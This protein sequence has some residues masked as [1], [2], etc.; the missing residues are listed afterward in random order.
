[1]KSKSHHRASAPIFNS[2]AV[3]FV[4][5]IYVLAAL[6][7]LLQGMPA[8]MLPT[9][10][11]T[12]AAIAGMPREEIVEQAGPLPAPDAS[13]DV[14]PVEEELLVSGTIIPSRQPSAVATQPPVVVEPS[15]S[16]P[17]PGAI[18]A[19]ELDGPVDSPPPP[20]LN[21]AAVSPP[22]AT[23][24]TASPTASTRRPRAG[25]SLVSAVE[26]GDLGRVRSLVDQGNEFLATTETGESLL[27]RASWH[28][29]KPLVTWLLEAGANPDFQSNRGLSALINAAIRGHGDVADALLSAGAS[30]NLASKDGRTALMAAAWNGHDGLVRRLLR[31]GAD[32]SAI[33]RLGRTALHYAAAS[34]QERSAIA[35]VE[36]GAN[37]AARDGSG[38]SSMELARDNGFE[39]EGARR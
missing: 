20:R 35:L 21:T 6:G 34:G 17:F 27:M 12:V 23:A 29:H 19:T 7:L 25:T 3:P 8:L 13:A 28:G 10:M 39:L 18:V 15:Y 2:T 1:M 30:V 32:V 26:S 22:D 14:N 4:V 36:A 24:A 38:R 16:P 33:D 9:G 31:G 37:L 5:G 11:A